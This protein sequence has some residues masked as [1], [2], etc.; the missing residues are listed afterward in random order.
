M[1][2]GPTAPFRSMDTGPGASPTRRADQGEEFKVSSG[3]GPLGRLPVV[4]FSLVALIAAAFG[5]VQLSVDDGAS[6]AEEALL[7]ARAFYEQ[8]PQVRVSA[9]NRQLLGSTFVDVV[10]TAYAQQGD[11]APKF[12]DR[13]RERT[14]DRFDA[15]ANRAYQAKFDEFP[16]WR[17]GVAPTGAAPRSYLTHAFVHETTLA[18]AVSLIFLGLIGI[19]LEAAFGSLIFGAVCLLGMVVPAAVFAASGVEGALPFSGASGLVATLLGAYLVRGMGSGGFILPGWLLLPV[20]GFIEYFFVRGVWVDNLDGLPLAAHGAALGLGVVGAV[21]IKMFDVER[22]RVNMEPEDDGLRLNPAITRAARLSEGGKH[23]EAFQ[24]L[25]AAWT[26]SRNDVT[27]ALAFWTAAKQTGNV[28]A[29]APAILPVIR[30]E[31]RQ[32]NVKEATRFWRELILAVPDWPAEP[33]LLIRMGESL[34]DEGHPEEAVATLRRAVEHPDGLGTVLAQRVVRIA[35]DL[36]PGLTQQAASVALDDVALDSGTRASLE[37]LCAEVRASTPP[38]MEAPKAPPAPQPTPIEPTTEETT[39]FPLDSDIDLNHTSE[40]T[41]PDEFHELTMGAPPDGHAVS[42]DPEEIDPNALSIQSLE[43]EF[44]GDLGL[45]QDPAGDAQSWN[46]PH[47]LKGLGGDGSETDPMIMDELGSPGEHA[48]DSYLDQGALSGDAL[49]QE[50]RLGSDPV[51]SPLVSDGPAPSAPNESAAPGALP[52]LGGMPE[53]SA[54]AGLP[55]LGSA[56][57]PENAQ[58]PP[59]P[60][61]DALGL[62]SLDDDLSIGGSL[63]QLKLVEGTPLAAADGVLELEIDGKGKSRVPFERVEAVA[64]AAVSGLSERPVIVID[65]VLNWLAIDDEP[66]KVI[67][68]YSNRFNPKRLSPA[69][70]SPLDALK[71]F[72]ADVMQQAGAT[73]LP[74]QGAVAGTPLATFESLGTYQRDVLMAED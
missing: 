34:L 53:P 56:P 70:A 59:E 10:G 73:A 55:P 27:V 29:A 71:S 42:P 66:L 19:G 64:M 23:G 24:V 22:K 58:S 32:G 67:R 69:A 1:G 33:T 47:A 28:E 51:S 16:A 3:N 26:E 60:A 6:K 45:E 2:G 65:L 48:D 68:L 5:Y 46:D 41:D 74:S 20:W 15:A 4:T 36:D 63:R 54:P 50:A 17:L 14:Q 39:D 40:L 38:A 13:M 62:A 31:I 12:S 44:S 25:D 35:R 37:V 72:A 61:D 7:R 43:R 8:N 11:M 49:S 30:N 18:L 57:E 21:A 52:P 9:R